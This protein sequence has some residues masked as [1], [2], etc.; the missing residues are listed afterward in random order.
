M[1]ALVIAPQPFFS[2]RGTPFSVYY[3]TLVTAEFGVEIDLL[4]YGEGQ[5]VEIP[6]V[7]IYRIPRFAALG[8]VKIGPSPLKGFL[9]VFLV[10]WTIVLLSRNRY[11]FVHAHEEAVFF[12]RFLKPLFGFR[13]LYDMHSSL[14]QQL[15]NFQFTEC[16]ALISL[17][18]RLEESCLRTADAVIS[19]CPDL[20]RYVEK[21]LG[22]NGKHLL[23]ENS[24]FEPVQIR[25]NTAI[26]AAEEKPVPLPSD[27]KLIV[28]AGT[29][30][31]YQGIDL[32]L[33]AF[34]EAVNREPAAFLLVVGGSDE[35][36]RA[37]RQQAAAIGLDEDCLFTGRVGQKLAKFY[38][39]K[40]AVLVSPRS[41]G[42]NTPLKI[43]EQIASGIPLVA[44][45][46]YSHTQV[47]DDEVAILVDPEPEAIS[48]GL[49]RALNGEG[50]GKA[51]KAR[52]LYEKSYSPAAYKRK[53]EHILELLGRTCVELQV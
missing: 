15:G 33:P 8:N 39:S 13:L 37:Y 40:A 14:P 51:V 10:I 35:Q 49:L 12:C 42:T 21:Q 9:D 46:I 47:L 7:R 5:D 45:R 48:L 34:K 32:L 27:R 24:I 43:Y 3:R 41:S 50:E 17:F 25:R 6:G 1:K 28:Y 44:T 20:A 52:Q 53:M 2:P 4:T 19:I 29:L 22:E 31:P 18:R 23:I 38:A 30:E 26:N 16:R 11:D 36:V